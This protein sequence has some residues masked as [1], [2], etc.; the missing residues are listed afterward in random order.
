[1]L[2]V[3]NPGSAHPQGRLHWGNAESF[4][5]TTAPDQ[6]AMIML[7]LPDLPTEDRLLAL[8]CHGDRDAITEIYDRYFEAIF[9][10]IRMRV[11]DDTLAEDLSAEVFLKLIAALQGGNAP[12]H[13]LRGWLFRVARN[14]LYDHYGRERQLAITALEEWIPAQPDSDPEARFFASADSQQIH[15]ALQALPTDQQEVLILRFGQMLSLEDTAA[16]M[17]RSISAIKS[18]QF[19]AASNLRAA[20]MAQE[21][22]D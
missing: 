9:Q 19:R 5:A 8:A 13:S 21:R 17:G 7:V 14:V 11:E 12:R 2:S 16:V 18:L 20:L 6:N 3:V 4:A 10:F 15:R 1:M 22:D